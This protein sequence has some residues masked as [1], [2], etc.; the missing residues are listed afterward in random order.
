MASTSEVFEGTVKAEV[1]LRIKE[2]YANWRVLGTVEL[3][4]KIRVYL[5]PEG[6]QKEI[7]SEEA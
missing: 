4:Y 1:G 5:Q 7:P 3:P 6:E 2:I